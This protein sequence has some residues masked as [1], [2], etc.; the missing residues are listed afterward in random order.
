[1]ADD[2]RKSRDPVLGFNYAVEITGVFVAGFSE[3]S[4]LNA[5]IETFDYREGGVNGYLHK[6]AGPVRYPSNLVLKKGITDSKDLWSW[7]WN[8]MNGTIQR[9]QVDVVLMDAA[10]DEKRRWTLQN[11]YPVKWAGP[12]LKAAASEVAVEAIELVHE[13]LSSR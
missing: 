1:M 13:G 8:V 12:D 3:V 10:G 5:E 11:A 6:F 7:Y 9:K 4:G 2:N